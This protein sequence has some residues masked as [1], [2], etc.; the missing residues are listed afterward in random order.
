MT[1]EILDSRTQFKC[2]QYIDQL[3]TVKTLYILIL[4]L[5]TIF[6]SLFFSL[7][8]SSCQVL[9][10]HV[11]TC[12]MLFLNVCSE[13]SDV[14]CAFYSRYTSAATTPK[15]VVI[16]LDSSGSM[17]GLRMEIAKM[18]V[19]KIMESLQENDYF[20][21]I[22]VSSYWWAWSTCLPPSLPCLH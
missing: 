6:Y 15:S 4:N 3:S 7:L 14:F 11:H 1:W 12:M 2:T 17:K 5:P 10:L 20:N 9:E 22:A 18:T 13:A 21:V 19:R 8:E 16:L